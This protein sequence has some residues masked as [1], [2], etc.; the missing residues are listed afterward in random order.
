MNPGVEGLLLGMDLGLD[1]RHIVA[2][3][4]NGQVVILDN[5]STMFKVIQNPFASESVVGVRMSEDGFLVFGAFSCVFYTLEGEEQDR[6]AFPKYSVCVENFVQLES[7]HH[8]EGIEIP[9]YDVSL[10]K[11]RI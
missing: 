2:Y 1:S 7:M 9:D 3:T 11:V 5:C 8:L 6:R 10:S 4:N